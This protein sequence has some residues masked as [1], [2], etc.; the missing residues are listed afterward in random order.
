VLH[1]GVF[2]RLAFVAAA[3]A[4]ASPAYALT[5]TWTVCAS[6]C[7][8]TTLAAA[9]ADA[10][11]ANGDTLRL[12]DATYSA[13]GNVSKNLTI[14]GYGAG[15]HTINVASGDAIRI[16]A[17][18][19]ATL[20]NLT[21]TGTGRDVEAFG[22]T[23]LTVDTCTFPGRTTTESGGGVYSAGTS[24]TIIGSTFSGLVGSSVTGAAIDTSATTTTITGSHFNGNSALTSGYYGG[25]IVVNGGTVTIDS[26]DFSNNSAYGGGAIYGA[27]GTLT[28]TNS[29][30]SS[31]STTS[32]SGGAIRW[33]SAGLLTVR[34]STFIDDTSVSSGGAIAVLTGNG[35][36][37][38]DQT[39]FQDNIATGQNGGAISVTST[40]AVTVTSSQFYGNRTNGASKNGGAIRVSGGGV[41]DVTIT[42]SI[43]DLN[44]ATYHGGAL[45]LESCDQVSIKDDTFTDNSTTNEAG[46]AVAV[47]AS[48]GLTMTRNSICDNTAAKGA[49]VDV[50]QVSASINLNNNLFVQNVSS[51]AWGG[52]IQIYSG[53]LASPHL[54]NN[55]FVY[56]SSPGPG[57]S[58]E[59]EADGVIAGNIISQT[60]AGDG[61]HTEYT[62]GAMS[63]IDDDWWQNSPSNLTGTF[64][65]LDSSNQFVDPAFLSFSTS[66]DDCAGDFRTR[67][68]SPFRNGGDPSALQN[69]RD[70]SRND[71]G[72]YGGP[73]ALASAWV[74][75]DGD[76]FPWVYDCND[77]IYATNPGVAEVGCNAIDD[78]CDGTVDE[79]SGGTYYQ[80]ADGD[81]FGR[82]SPPVTGCPGA[83]Y[84]ANNTDCNDASAAIKP[85]AQEIC[86]PSNTDEDCDTLA[87]DAD[88]S[89]TGKSTWYRDADADGFGTSATT[90]S[91]CDAPAGYVASSTDCNDAS[92]AVHPGGIEVCDAG[93]L[94][95][96]CDGAADDAD[97]GGATG[98]TAFYTDADGD[99]Y[100][101]GAAQQRCDASAGLVATSGD[102]D[103]A[104]SAVHPGGTEV[105][106]ASNRD[107]DCDGLA[108]D[109][110]T[111]GATGKTSFYADGD[112]DGYGAGT[113]TQRCD[114]S[115]GQVANNT[116]CND[117]IATIHPGGQEICDASNRD[118][119][120]DGLVDDGDAS[121]S[122]GTKTT[123]YADPDGDTYGNA[124]STLSKCDAPAGYVAT[125][126]DCDSSNPAINPGGTEVCDPANADEDCDG[127]ADDLDAPGASGK[128][129]WYIDGDADGYGNP[130]V[131][132][133]LCD[134]PAGKVA[135]N[136]DCNDGSALYHPGAPESCGDP[137]YNCDG[138]SGNTDGDGDSVFACAGDC[139]DND[140]TVH[141][142][143]AE[144]CNGK[145]DD[146]DGQ[147]DEAGATGS[148]GF[149]ADTDGDGFGDPFVVTSA[150]TAPAG[151][152]LDGT[153]CDDTRAAA[154]PGAVEVCN[155]ADDDCDGNADD[156]LAT[157]S[158]YTD[159]DGDGYGNPTG[160]VSRC[161]APAGT[162]ADGTD[163]NDTSTAQHP[164]ATEVCNGVDDDCDGLVD[165]GVAV[166]YHADADADGFGSS[167]NSQTACAAPVGYVVDGTDCNDAIAAIHPGATELCNGVD[168]DCNGTVDGGLSTAFYADADG[169]G[170]GDDA[171]QAQ[172]A[173]TAPAGTVADHTDCDDTD[174]AIYVGATEV[175]DGADQ[176]CDGQVDE[177]ATD[178]TAYYADTDGDGHGD[179]G[180]SVLACT[181]PAGYVASADDCDDAAPA[182]HPGAGEQCNGSD[183]DCNGLVD[184]N[185]V[186]QV[187]YVDGDGD[188]F[189]TTAATQTDCLQPAGYVAASGDCDDA[190]TTVHPGAD[191]HCDGVDEDCDGTIDGPT[192]I[193]AVVFYADTDGDGFGD[194]A[195]PVTGCSA[196]AGTVVDATDCDDADGG[197]HP[198]ALEHCDGVDEDCDAT[199]DNDVAQF[200]FYADTDGDGWGDDANT[201]L[202]CTATSGFVAVG[203]DCD[204]TVAAVNP[205]GAEICNAVDDDCD[206]TIDG[207]SAIDAL[208][209][210]TDADADGFGDAASQSR[211]CVAPSGT[212]DNAADCD[213]TDA[214]IGDGF[215]WFT[216]A[217][218]D[219]FGD[220]ATLAHACTSPLGTIGVGGDCADDD[221]DTWPGATEICDGVDN[222]CD[223]L[224]D[225]GATGATPWYR[226]ADG[227]G[228]GDARNGVLACT[229]PAGY[230][231][232]DDDCDDLRDYVFTGAP[233][234]C[235]SRDDDCNGAIDDDVVY[236]D[237]WTDADLDG[238]GDADATPTTA[239]D[240]VAGTSADGEDCDDGDADV[241]PDADE[242]CDGVDDDCDG[243]VD[244]DASDALVWYGDADGDGYGDA[245]AVA[246]ACDAPTG[247][248]A[249]DGDCDDTDADVNP[250][251]YERCANEVDDDC[252]GEVDEAVE[253]LWYADRDGDG[254]GDPASEIETCDPPDGYVTVGED[255]DDDD[256]DVF[257]G[258][259]DAWYD[260]VDSDCDG[261]DDDDQDGDG[262]AWDARGG[263]DCNDEDADIHPG[264]TDAT[265]DGIDQDCDGT[266]GPDGGDTDDT[267]TGETHGRLKLSG[268]ACDGAGGPTGAAGLVLIALALV[269]RRRR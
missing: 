266:D 90:S 200:T 171:A 143:A 52:A 20:K 43:F 163:C 138:A 233:E 98:K 46:G 6:S 195:A 116:D 269:T 95:E 129:N 68:T 136:T 267:D 13:G 97:A 28:V 31:S 35:S 256:P 150:C 260:G 25:A 61:M 82:A 262:A 110:D 117:A 120:C 96:D 164:G 70:G 175:C 50:E 203:G 246:Y 62:T 223:G 252:D 2:R 38:V 72:L 109:A 93:N 189:G 210:F 17:G 128:T 63:V 123:W 197:V 101:A 1:C 167:A 113:A 59:V 12:T 33:A 122:A 49:G 166:T 83:G 75:A 84:V 124:A 188:G 89:V 16:N 208:V 187:W 242:V 135:S 125:S 174:A 40:G 71:L 259:T 170:F 107:E 10:G 78:N 112:A 142:G 58:I 102:C 224:V 48:T 108:D 14:E 80:D 214:A 118:E 236:F 18:M 115:G 199:I 121:V 182:V 191:E 265:V 130:G 104:S 36:L 41:S 39:G 15:T 21:I 53:P 255:C 235:N 155:G 194:P 229:P 258:A 141:P 202:D 261:A 105:C 225:I 159:A 156:G 133:P 27:A 209:F 3:V 81:G 87:D 160:A 244:V 230:V 154:H 177:N 178:R 34:L 92:S 228:Q 26:S 54:R 241:N 55:V 106:D 45:S 180:A 29:T 119:D 144:G 37:L 222:D 157:S 140:A 88:P 232:N 215:D 100:G 245:T 198:G 51:G 5:Q 152:V 201:Q 176:D 192:A 4:F 205:N 263:D 179:P 85:G 186:N 76:G 220:D 66:A 139:N 131:S 254:F 253:A 257:P 65:V 158:W 147:V 239:C 219:G 168:D 227:D 226:D 145:D 247:A 212:V 251:A 151:Y 238:Y 99:G 114:A 86:D 237:V 7:N 32:A 218:G 231:G 47:L 181:R 153:D 240:L 19:T 22:T 173:C 64:T 243:T 221:A 249:L 204:D 57:G 11:V 183:D 234:R 30:L 127:G 172:L 250:A 148:Y 91:A 56:N 268:C 190:V 69:D 60:Q 184:D 216:D 134:Q 79:G 149:F 207:P 162:V 165:D 132:T 23:T 217:D 94:D 206:G 103:D 137:D 126:G 196:P 248:S 77:G 169:D 161:A 42:G 9:I 193:D 264:A 73:E 111:G 74:D 213:D 146:C 185:V 8:F 44:A 24:L 211:D 67:Y